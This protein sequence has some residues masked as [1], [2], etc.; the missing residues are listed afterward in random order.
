[1]SRLY[2]LASDDDDTES[3]DT[4]EEMLLEFGCLPPKNNFPRYKFNFLT[5]G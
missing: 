4:I 3:D 2:T 5:L 1:M